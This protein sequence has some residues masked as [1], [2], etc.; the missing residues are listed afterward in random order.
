MTARR[1]LADTV[2][3][4]CLRLL[5]RFPDLPFVVPPEP[6]PASQALWTPESSPSSPGSATKRSRQSQTSTLKKAAAASLP[7]TR[8]RQDMP[9]R[10]KGLDRPEVV[11]SGSSLD[12]SGQFFGPL[13]AH[14]RSMFAAA[15]DHAVVFH[16]LCM[17]MLR[18]ARGV[19]STILQA[20]RTLHRTCQQLAGSKKT[21][22]TEFVSQSH[23]RQTGL[24][25]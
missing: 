14:T 17:T 7:S 10:V 25:A 23:H 24:T 3:E 11:M 18:R 9:S 2:V 19:D 8:R 6:P 13:E 20:A 15:E 1:V 4:T 21:R 16:T 5:R 22:P 12:G